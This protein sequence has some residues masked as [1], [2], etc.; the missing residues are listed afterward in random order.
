[1]LKNNTITIRVITDPDEMSK[2]HDITK[3]LKELS[4]ELVEK[5]Y[6]ERIPGR[7]AKTQYFY[8][9]GFDESDVCVAVAVCTPNPIRPALEIDDFIVDKKYRKEGIGVQLLDAVKDLAQRKELI[10]VHLNCMLPRAAAGASTFYAL[11]ALP[12]TGLRYGVSVKNKSPKTVP[13]ELVN[14]EYQI[15]KLHDVE[16]VARNSRELLTEKLEMYDS[17]AA[18][19]QG[20]FRKKLA[21][22]HSAAENVA[23]F[24]AEKP[25]TALP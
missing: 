1:M 23:D 2:R 7:V 8:I 17:A 25:A 14:L 19:I 3:L 24:V 10:S 4:T 6:E 21:A 16:E 20:F 11:A 9:G 13:D 15:K 18:V 12:P 22:L 5:V